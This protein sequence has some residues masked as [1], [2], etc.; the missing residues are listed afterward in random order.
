MVTHQFRLATVGH[1]NGNSS[2]SNYAGKKKIYKK[3]KKILENELKKWT[4][5]TRQEK[6][7]HRV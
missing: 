4:K 5:K 1:V 6:I 3:I 2:V 7:S